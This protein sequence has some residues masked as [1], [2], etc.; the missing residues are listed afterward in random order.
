MDELNRRIRELI[1]LQKEIREDETLTYAAKSI[2]LDDIK[3]ELED[4]NQL[5]IDLESNKT[6]EEYDEMI[7]AKILAR[8]QA[9]NRQVAIDKHSSANSRSDLI[10]KNNEK[11]KATR[12]WAEQYEKE[13]YEA[14][15]KAKE[16]RE[17]NQDKENMINVLT[18]VSNIGHRNLRRM[19][20][21]DLE[22]TFED[23]LA[24]NGETL[25]KELEKQ[26]LTEWAEKR[27]SKKDEN[28]LNSSAE[29]STIDSQKEVTET[30]KMT[31]EEG[32]QLMMK[33]G[34]EDYLSNS[35]NDAKTIEN[36]Q[37][38]DNEAQNMM[39]N[40]GIAQSNMERPVYADPNNNLTASN[41]QANSGE[42]DATPEIAGEET[43]EQNNSNSQ[44]KSEGRQLV[45]RIKEGTQLLK[46]K[47]TANNNQ[48]IKAIAIVVAAGAAVLTAGAALGVSPALLAT[49]GVAGYGANEFNKGRKL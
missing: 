43:V 5:A 7:D 42:V 45:S 48:A 8:K 1:S 27:M 2:A 33:I 46:E 34:K 49:A 28:N 25:K 4:C 9:E 30:G 17:Y 3:R 19:N 18:S 22:R 11:A 12:T 40:A 24:N 15:Q 35:E 14:E 38:S 23:F 32:Q 44:E 21:E 39:A 41:I 29:N 36:G 37:V 47:L 20:D 10:D 31:D 13:S 6:Q 26:G 16:E